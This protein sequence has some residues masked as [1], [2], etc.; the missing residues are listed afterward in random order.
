MRQ[1]EHAIWGVL[2]VAAVISPTR[3]TG[4]GGDMPMDSAVSGM[5]ASMA[6]S[7]ADGPHMHMTPLASPQPGD[8]RRAQSVATALREA[9][10]PYADYHRAL[11][12]GFV[13]FAP[14]VPQHIYHFAR[15]RGAFIRTVSFD[16]ARP[17]SLLYERT[18]DSTYRLVGA[19]YTAPL[20]ASLADLNARIPLSVAQ[21]HEHV[22]LCIPSA[23]RDASRWAE[24]GPDGQP[25]FGPRGS[26]ATEAACTAAGGRFLSHFYGWMVHVY[27][28][29]SD[30]AAIWGRGDM[31]HM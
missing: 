16:P 30:T 8:S 13:I 14:R 18:G 23:P 10:A 2:V 9:L 11:A 17:T 20:W 29:A 21:W 6:G 12:D 4:Q 26:I 1:A 24:R 3:A 27:P 7:M 5:H 25:L 22:N 31:E 15:R 19:M 28:F